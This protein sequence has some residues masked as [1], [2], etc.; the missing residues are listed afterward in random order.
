MTRCYS[1]GLYKSSGT[2]LFT[3]NICQ[4]ETRA[5]RQRGHA[6]VVIARF[7][8]I[9]FANNHCWVDSSTPCAALDAF[10]IAVTLQVNSN[11]FQEARGS[12]A[13][14]GFTF[15]LM[16]I[17]TANLSTYQLF[18]LAIVPAMM[19]NANNLSLN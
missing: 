11:R 18:P 5:S 16:N 9:L 17:T 6:S 14:S 4:L 3:N 1:P 2:V 13:A 15:G 10:L 7:D 12:V 19:M 8:H